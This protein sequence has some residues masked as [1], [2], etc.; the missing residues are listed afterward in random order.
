MLL[1]DGDLVD[2]HVVVVLVEDHE[3]VAR[4]SRKFKKKCRRLFFFSV[5]QDVCVYWLA[6]FGVAVSATHCS[7]FSL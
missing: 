4:S 3:V 5:W 7:V 6:W 2:E 1:I